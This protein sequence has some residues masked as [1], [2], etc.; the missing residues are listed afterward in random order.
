MR[1]LVGGPGTY[2]GDLRCVHAHLVS[3]RGLDEAKVERAVSHLK[4]IASEMDL[5]D[6][7]VSEIMRNAETAKA[8]ILG[9]DVPG[10][11][12]RASSSLYARLGGDESVGKLVDE[13]HTRLQALPN[14]AH[15]YDGVD[16]A[17]Q[18]SCQLA[19]LRSMWGSGT[20]SRP[21][22]SGA[23]FALTT[24]IAHAHLARGRSLSA[25]HFRT[26]EEVLLESLMAQGT[27]SELIAEV[28]CSLGAGRSLIYP[29]NAAA[30]CP[31][32]ST[33]G[34]DDERALEAIIASQLT[35]TTAVEVSSGA[36]LTAAATIG[37]P[38]IAPAGAVQQSTTSNHMARGSSQARSPDSSDIMC[39]AGGVGSSSNNDSINGFSGGGG[40]GTSGNNTSPGPLAAEDEALLDSP[41]K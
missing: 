24:E 17:V 15:I 26:I 36:S 8:V 19:F 3:E 23:A 14:L 13:L 25:Y 32:V 18:R 10:V 38:T 30:G 20:G 31:F 12:G 5:P 35:A 39:D 37:R 21:G 34:M 22:S 2:S 4:T 28:R 1:Y 33:L 11:G 40:G 27:S 29:P 16:M 41:L 6:D 9:T 7:V